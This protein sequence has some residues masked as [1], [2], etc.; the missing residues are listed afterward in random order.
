MGTGSGGRGEGWG[1]GAGADR[2]EH[3][4]EGRLAAGAI[5]SADGGGRSHRGRG[6]NIVS[7]QL[8]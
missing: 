3:R 6:K 1:G 4:V 5:N 7:I 8:M 2:W